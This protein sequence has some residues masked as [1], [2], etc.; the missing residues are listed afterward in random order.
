MLGYEKYR[1]ENKFTYKKNNDTKSITITSN[2][3]GISSMIYLGFLFN[4]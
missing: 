2:Y 4:H 1:E 3:S